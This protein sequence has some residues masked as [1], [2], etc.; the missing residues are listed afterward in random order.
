MKLMILL[1]F[2]LSAESWAKWSVSTYN[3]RNFD[4]EPG[5]SANHTELA[6]IIKSVKSDVMAFEEVVNVP[7]FKKLIKTTLPG[8]AVRIS[9]CG[10]FGKQNLAVAYNPSVFTFVSEA[11]DLSF[12]GSEGNSCGSLRPVFFVTLTHTES[13][14]DFIFGVV[15]LKAGGESDA[16]AKRWAQYTKLAAVAALNHEYNLILLGDFN[17]TGYNLQDQDFDKFETFMK[18]AGLQT[19]SKDIGCSSYWHGGQGDLEYQASLLDHIV[20]QSDLVASVQAIKLGGH[21]AEQECQPATPEELGRGFEKVSDHCP[22]QV[23]FE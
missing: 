2:F 20:L 6:N 8:Y 14:E 23:T 21:C 3:I 4:K 19:M 5:G 12:S 16:M 17:T 22:V 7:A 13:D 18:K 9:T 1:A 15:H 11:E 10:G